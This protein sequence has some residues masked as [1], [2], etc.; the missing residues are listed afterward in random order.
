[1]SSLS[2][3]VYQVWV[4]HP[5]YTSFMKIF[6]SEERDDRDDDGHEMRERE[7]EREERRDMELIIIE[8]CVLSID[9]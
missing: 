9:L 8:V 4:C 6:K 3:D 2:M 1:M 7:M 5:L